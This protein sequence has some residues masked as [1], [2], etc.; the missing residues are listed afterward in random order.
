MR[1]ES[2]EQTCIMFEMEVVLIAV[3]KLY[4][5]QSSHIN[6]GTTEIYT[7]MLVVFRTTKKHR[8][9]VSTEAIVQLAQDTHY[10]RLHSGYR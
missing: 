4:S 7:K 5:E 1:R 9:F 8:F 6:T 10:L 3:A 2:K